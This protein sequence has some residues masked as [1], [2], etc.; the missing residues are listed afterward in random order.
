M[1]ELGSRLLLKPEKYEQPPLTSTSCIETVGQCDSAA[2]GIARI[3]YIERKAMLVF[4]IPC[5]KRAQKD[6][7]ET[8]KRFGFGSV[9]WDGHMRE[10]IVIGITNGIK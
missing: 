1:E 4:T 7:K 10:D 5:E 8:K 6:T 2:I 9:T 3:L